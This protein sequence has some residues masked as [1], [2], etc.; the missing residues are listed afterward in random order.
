MSSRGKTYYVYILGSRRGLLY[1][2]VTSDLAR[3]LVEHRTSAVPGYTSRYRISRL[4]FFEETSDALSAISREKE[5]KGWRRSKKVELIEANN[6]TFADLG[7]E[8]L[9]G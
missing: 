9:D 3:R 6:P 8:I 7:D 2:G 5:I 4:L 1:T